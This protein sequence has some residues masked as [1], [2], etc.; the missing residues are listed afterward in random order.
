MNYLHIQQTFETSTF[1]PNEISIWVKFISFTNN[2]PLISTLPLNETSGLKF[3][4]ATSEK[5]TFKLELSIIKVFCEFLC[6]ILFY[7]YKL[8]HLLQINLSIH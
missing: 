1:L 7:P 5:S 3:T 4:C 6:I 8:N 2:E